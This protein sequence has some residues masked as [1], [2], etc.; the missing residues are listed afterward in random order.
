MVQVCITNS[1]CIP[2]SF[3][4]SC[5]ITVL[6][7]K[8]PEGCVELF[9]VCDAVIYRY[10]RGLMTA[11]NERAE[12]LMTKLDEYADS[13]TPAHIHKLVRGAHYT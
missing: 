1:M 10:L 3:Q 8:Y 12:C 13:L 4:L 11:F 9:Q 6:S 5:R 7:I 2:N